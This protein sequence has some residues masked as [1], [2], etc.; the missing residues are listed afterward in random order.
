MAFISTKCAKQH[1]LR[2]DLLGAW[3]RAGQGRF[4]E[5]R[6]TGPVLQGPSGQGQRYWPEIALQGSVIPNKQRALHMDE[7]GLREGV[8]QR[9]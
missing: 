6:N 9:C 4:E 8:L 5:E 7:G 2:E 3:C 1:T